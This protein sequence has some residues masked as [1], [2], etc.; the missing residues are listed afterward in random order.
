MHRFLPVLLAVIALL[1]VFLLKDDL[2]AWSKA[3]TFAASPAKNELSSKSFVERVL[4]S[5]GSFD[6]NASSA[7][8]FNK[9]VELPNKS[10]AVL[11]TNEPRNVLGDSTSEKW[12]DVDLSTQRLYAK[13]GDR[14]VYEFPI[15]SGLPWFP[16]VTGDFRIWAKVK[17]QR[18]SGG[19]IADGT[20]Y[21]LPNV[22]YVQYFH[23]GYGIHGA[24]WHNDFGK[25]RSHGCINMRPED[26]KTLFFWTNPPVPDNMGAIYKIAPQD[27]TRVVVHGTTPTQL[28]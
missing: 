20:F 16:T 28:N 24:Y 3:K 9:K 13:E 12:I 4:L 15:S 5:D 2:A 10:L 1:S 7:V 17:A 6:P 19:S 26:A 8:W 18:M 25:P 14:T 23:N 21:D 22:P 11:M 27:S